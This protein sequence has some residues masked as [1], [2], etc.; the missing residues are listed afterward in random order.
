MYLQFYNLNKLFNKKNVMINSKIKYRVI[1]GMLFIFG[2]SKLHLILVLGAIKIRYLDVKI[3]TH[4][5]YDTLMKILLF[6]HKT[7]M[8]FKYICTLKCTSSFKNH[9]SENYFIY[10]FVI[11]TKYFSSICIFPKK[12]QTTHNYS[13]SLN[14]SHS[15]FTPSWSKVRN[16]SFPIHI[17]DTLKAK[18]KLYYAKKLCQYLTFYKKRKKYTYLNPFITSIS[19]WVISLAIRQAV[20]LFICSFICELLSSGLM[21]NNNN[22]Q[23]NMTIL[24]R[25]KCTYRKSFIYKFGMNKRYCLNILKISDIFNIIYCVC[26]CKVK[27]KV[28]VSGLTPPHNDVYFFVRL[29]VS[30]L[31]IQLFNIDAIYT[32]L[33]KK[34]F[35]FNNM[36]CIT[37]NELLVYGD[38]FNL[39][40]FNFTKFEELP[41]LFYRPLGYCRTYIDLTLS[42]VMFENVRLLKEA[43][44]KY[45][46]CAYDYCDQKQR[47]KIN[48]QTCCKYHN[49]RV[50]VWYFLEQ[51]KNKAEIIGIFHSFFCT[52]KKQKRTEL[53]C[54][55]LQKSIKAHQQIV[56]LHIIKCCNLL[57]F[58]LVLIC[59]ICIQKSMLTASI[60]SDIFISDSTLLNFGTLLTQASLQRRPSKND[61]NVY[62]SLKKTSVIVKFSINKF[63]VT[64]S[65][66]IYVYLLPVLFL[67]F[68][69]FLNYIFTYAVTLH[70]IINVNRFF[71]FIN[72]IC[73]ILQ[74]MKICIEIPN[75]FKYLGK[76]IQ[77]NFKLSLLVMFNKTIYGHNLQCTPHVHSPCKKVL[78]MV[79]HLIFHMYSVSNDYCR[80]EKHEKYR[81]FCSFILFLAKLFSKFSIKVDKL[82]I[83]EK[84]PKILNFQIK[85]KYFLHSLGCQFIN[86]SILVLQS[87]FRSFVLFYLIQFSKRPSLSGHPYIWYT[88]QNVFLF[89]TYM[90]SVKV[91]KRGRSTS[92]CCSVSGSYCRVLF[93]LLKN[94]LFIRKVIS[95]YLTPVFSEYILIVC[96][97]QN[98][99]QNKEYR[100]A[101]NHFQVKD[102]RPSVFLLSNVRR[103][104]QNSKSCCYQCHLAVT[105]IN[106]IVHNSKVA[107]HEKEFCK[108]LVRF[109]IQKGKLNDNNISQII[110]SV[111]QYKKGKIKKYIIKLLMKNMSHSVRN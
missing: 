18:S 77:Q 76:R 81:I 65:D 38:Y 13:L 32:Y 11:S 46:R 95:T 87:L 98:Y 83:K 40:N 22:K 88:T 44:T 111:K 19:E 26:L 100:L 8:Y 74:F 84:L 55:A 27:Q 93:L 54:V 63:Y 68:Q 15:Y 73:Y 105:K 51:F 42:P 85:H 104:G 48:F 82:R 28:G 16:E 20:C 86:R 108:I 5:L 45:I 67:I 41:A 64:I 29:C 78:N 30:S 90:N 75:N 101:R 14:Y 79:F 62:N 70:F 96:N 94:N 4:F 58:G 89:A 47:F 72:L 6:F 9:G 50:L 57:H 102:V 12:Y 39:M 49:D 61:I 106:N 10:K 23:K 43:A 24:R 34:C 33:T 109:N 56:A 103:I 59:L 7:L 69:L 2:N 36:Y 99:T 3:K 37:F 92:T 53:K 97:A 35:F 31:S 110:V 71:I 25:M 21:P 52:T 60:D 91:Y 17:S 80:W 66:S 1:R 107:E